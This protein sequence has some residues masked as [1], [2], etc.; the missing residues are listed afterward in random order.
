MI[1]PG[2]TR[3]R[4]VR[5]PSPSP[6]PYDFDA[7]DDAGDSDQNAEFELSEPSTDGSDSLRSLRKFIASSS[8]DSDPDFDGNSQDDS[9]TSSGGGQRGSLSA[10]GDKKYEPLGSLACVVAALDKIQEA[11]EALKEAVERVRYDRLEEIENG[12]G[13]VRLYL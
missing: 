4:Q 6:E 9:V 10:A 3:M 13:G 1:T 2:R 5:S 11:L 8:Q 7:S 12:Q